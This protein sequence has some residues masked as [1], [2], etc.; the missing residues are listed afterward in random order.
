ML[1]DEEFSKI[2]RKDYDT[3]NKK[4]RQEEK[5]A[6]SRMLSEIRGGRENILQKSSVGFNCWPH[7]RNER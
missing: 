7:V 1:T 4:T 6:W 5:R 3:E 2:N